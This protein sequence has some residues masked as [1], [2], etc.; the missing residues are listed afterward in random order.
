V[1]THSSVDFS[2][3]SDMAT[4]G[5]TITDP[6]GIA[7]DV[8]FT[9]TFDAN[10]VP[11][12]QA[13][14]LNDADHSLEDVAAFVGLRDDPFIRTPRRGRNVLSLVLDMPL[15]LIAHG[16]A[17]TILVWAVAQ[18]PGETHQIADRAGRALRS[19]LPQFAAFNQYINP[20]SDFTVLDFANPDVVICNTLQPAVYPNCR[21]LTD[22][23]VHSVCPAG[24]LANNGPN[25]TQDNCTHPIGD[26]TNDKPFLSTFPYLAPPWPPAT[27]TGYYIN[28]HGAS[29]DP[30][31]SGSH[32]D[33]PDACDQE[34]WDAGNGGVCQ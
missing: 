34:D 1:D 12:L 9:L 14:G 15:H 26:T 11:T 31:S 3:A 2:N 18:V 20:A 25:G 6:A 13:D 32:P 22:D 21:G 7:P 24:V 17:P 30:G 23:V 27:D 8:S 28:V 16:A 5:G 29:T 10:G 4:Y 19:M 33:D